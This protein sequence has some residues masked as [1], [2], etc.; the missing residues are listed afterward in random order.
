MNI[1]PMVTRRLDTEE[2]SLITPGSVYV[3]EERGPHAELTGVGIERWTDGIRW[4]PSRVREGFLFYH[5]KQD[6]HSL[7][8][9]SVYDPNNVSAC[10]RDSS[11][12]ILIKQT[13][14]VYV[15]TPR[16]QRK[17]HLIAYFTE[18]S[19]EH[20]QCVDDLPHLASLPVPHGRYKSA[21]SAKGRPEHIY[22]ADDHQ[23]SH[24]EYIPYTPKG[25]SS[26]PPISP[27][28]ESSYSPKWQGR[29]QVHAAY[30]LGHSSPA[31]PLSPMHSPE[32]PRRN[33]PGAENLAPLVY[34][35]A[36]SP[37][38]R[39]PEDEKTLKL[40]ASGTRAHNFM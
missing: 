14:T 17:W 13:Y 4:G 39:Y 18:E 28:K 12:S 27:L 20:L 30:P 7:Y 21:R 2:R 37:P 9:D 26:P 33:H 11:R 36:V 6:H 24:V 38:R 25:L 22:G 8:S 40:L 3:W 31:S 1:L 34:L 19:L 23:N 35:Q 5:E 29:D 16:G 15:E 10:R 32:R